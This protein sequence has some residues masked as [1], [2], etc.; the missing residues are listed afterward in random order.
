M[1]SPLDNANPAAAPEPRRW[2]RS[3]VADRRDDTPIDAETQPPRRAEDDIPVLTEVVP[4]R[5][6]PPEPP[7]PPPPPLDTPAAFDARLED[8]AAQ[9]AQA[10]EEQMAYELPT[11]IEA[12][13]LNVLEDL[14]SGINSTMEAALRDF[15]SRRRQL[16]LPL[17]GQSLP[18]TPRK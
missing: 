7:P 12:T 18:W 9:M 15:L 13:L 17:D 10:I 2:R 1:S 8:L 4:A 3:F 16:P 6:E 14:R 11:L 5:E